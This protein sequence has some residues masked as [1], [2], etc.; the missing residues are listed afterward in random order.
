MQKYQDAVF[1][2]T[3]GVVVG[4]SVL[5]QTFPAG[6]TATIYSDNGV[7]ISANPLT[8]DANGSFAFYAADGRYQLQ[9]SG[10][11]ITARTVSDVIIEDPQDSLTFT[12]TNLLAAFSSTVNSYNQVALQNKSAGATASSELV[13]YPDNGTEAAG[14]A[15]L[16]VNSSANADPVYTCLGQNEAF[17][18]GSTVNAA[19]TGNLVFAT[20]NTGTANAIQMYS[21][22]FTQA[23]TAYK[24]N[25][26]SSGNILTKPQTTPPTLTVNGDMVFN[27]TSNTNLRISVRGSDGVTRV[28]NITLT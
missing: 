14:W 15:I 27:L 23:K 12:G 3:G 22:N 1:R 28:A 13:V 6:A 5:V 8:T 24:F 9:I 16:G 18:I 7:T 26:D 21:G 10:S 19:K 11:G 20:G 4:A 2:S 25:L 17:V